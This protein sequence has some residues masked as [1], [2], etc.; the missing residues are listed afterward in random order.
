MGFID[1]ALGTSPQVLMIRG[2]RS[3]LLA[4]NIAN[5]DTPGYKARDMDFKSALT[6]AV[7]RQKAQAVKSTDH[8]HSRHIELPSSQ[9]MMYGQEMM[10]RVPL[11]PSVDG[12]T[13]E[14]HVEQSA[15]MDNAVRYQASANFLDN[16][17]RSLISALKG[18]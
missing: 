9:E 18:E 12:N 11:Q 6:A 1:K 13:V 17:V 8:T 7:D 3:E 5:A 4:A 16:K 15:F 10:Y 2:R 14:T